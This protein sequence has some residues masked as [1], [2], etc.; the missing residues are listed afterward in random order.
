MVENN[1]KLHA[2]SDDGLLVVVDKALR[3]VGEAAHGSWKRQ[4]QARSVKLALKPGSPLPVLR[5]AI[6]R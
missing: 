5:W 2:A 4:M 6:Q 1:I 3:R